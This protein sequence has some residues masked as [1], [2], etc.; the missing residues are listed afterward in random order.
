A[1]NGLSY[2]GTTL[3]SV[4]TT[5]GNN[6][7]NN[8]SANVGI[9]T[10]SPSNLLTVSGALS[11]SNYVQLVTNTTKINS[12]VDDGLLI[13]A[14]HYC[15]NSAKQ[16]SIVACQRPD[17]TGLG[18]IS[19]SACAGCTY[20]TTSDQRLKENIRDTKFGLDGLMKI[21]V[22]DYNYKSDPSNQQ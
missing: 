5:S 20:L 2:S 12:S 21:Q 9:G 4:W 16:S 7:S 15:F 18:R 13:K 10:S 1:G 3:N 11:G 8:N 6:I 17:G 19:Q 22:S 14:R